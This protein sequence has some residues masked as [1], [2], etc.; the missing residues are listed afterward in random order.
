[1]SRALLAVVRLDLA[2]WRRSPWAIVSALF[3]PLGMAV[4]LAML[5]LSVGRQPVALVVQGAGPEAR[6]MARVIE[7][8]TEAYALTVTD[9]ETAAGM[10]HDQTAA[11]VI[12]IPPGFDEAVATHQATLDLTLN[13]V[14]VDFADDIRRTVAR[15][16]AEFDAP[17]LGIQGELAGPSRGV[18]LPNPYRVAIAERPLR[19]TNVDFLRYQVLPALVLLVLTVGLM[20]TALLSARDVE[21]G[22]AR[23]MVLSPQPA[24]RLVA[25]RFA[26]G[27]A[28]CLLVLLPILAIASVMGVIAPPVGHW[29]ALLG[30]F[31]ATALCAAGLGAAL[32]AWLRRARVVAMAASIVA[33]YLFFL[34]GGFTTIAFLPGWLRGLSAGVPIR[35]AI[36]GMRQCLFY[37]DLHGVG[38]DL[39]VLGATALIAV[40]VGSLMVRRAWAS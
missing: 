13:N 9:A 21:Q 24:W 40:M 16:V 25:G 31:V 12:V 5:T 15:S 2:L 18:L 11:A 8:D 14:D 17:Q 6:S 30:V 3:P 1:M 27:V 19:E 26:G 35:Y 7:A 28:I 4:L 29:P 34:G 20:G 10:L 33:T 39:L 23:L 38:L 22:T 37:A 32:G 36:D